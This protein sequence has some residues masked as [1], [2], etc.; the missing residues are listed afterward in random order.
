MAGGMTS[1]RLRERQNAAT[2]EHQRRYAE[3]LPDGRC[4][5][6]ASG[7]F[8]QAEQPHHVADRI[9]RLLARDS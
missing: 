7:H 6:V 3:A 8:I 5:D 1:V 9:R 2:R 4:E